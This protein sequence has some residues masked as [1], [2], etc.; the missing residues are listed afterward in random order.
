MPIMATNVQ[1][2]VCGYNLTG[3]AIGSNCPECGSSVDTSLYATSTGPPMGK[4]ITALVLGI[5]SIPTCCCPPV[6]GILG[7]IG[8]IFGIL[9]L[10][11][12]P[13]GSPGGA[14]G[15]AMAGLICS[16]IGVGITVV[17]VGIRIVSA[18]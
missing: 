7:V 16:I 3:V 8:L 2:S 1:C 18:F 6:S 4:A 11:E 15:M 5:C 13:Q 14:R 17:F 12:I 10:N 9:A